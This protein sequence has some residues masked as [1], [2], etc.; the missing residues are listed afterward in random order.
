LAEGGGYKLHKFFHG[1]ISFRR[2]SNAIV[3]IYVDRAQILR[4]DQ[5]VISVVFYHL[6]R[7]FQRV[8]VE[9]PGLGKMVFKSL[10]NEEGAGLINHL[11]LKEIKEAVYDCD[12]FKSHGPDDINLGF[13]KDF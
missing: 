6:S 1:V 3:F 13:F 10:S 11:L 5:W 2:C 4:G 9:R 8:D 7:H 12:S